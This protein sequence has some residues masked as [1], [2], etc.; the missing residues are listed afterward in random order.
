MLTA[1]FWLSNVSFSLIKVCLQFPLTGFGLYTF[2]FE[3]WRNTFECSYLLKGLATLQW[4]DLG[5]ESTN[6]L[7]NYLNN[8]FK[9]MI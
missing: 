6:Y 4:K 7:S 8:T 2:Y 5:K 1:L 3:A 9:N